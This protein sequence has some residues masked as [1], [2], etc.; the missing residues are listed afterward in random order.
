MAI[1]AA[2]AAW[3]ATGGKRY[4]F[5]AALLR[6]LSHAPPGLRPELAAAA[7]APLTSRGKE[8][9]ALFS[10]AR[11]TIAYQQSDRR[12]GSQDADGGG[13]PGA[14]VRLSAAD[15]DAVLAGACA[16]F[17]WPARL[18]AARK[19][20]E[21]F[22]DPEEM[23]VGGPRCVVFVAA[24]VAALKRAEGGLKEAAVQDGLKGV[25]QASMKMLTA[26]TEVCATATCH[27]VLST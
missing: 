6:R 15:A 12:S 21:S 10:L 1:N 19:L 25:L 13:G 11:A 16:R 18:A 14:P 17:P 26:A 4:K 22:V 8:H 7:V 27:H 20:L 23:A 3:R 9:A 5:L 24:E 2:A